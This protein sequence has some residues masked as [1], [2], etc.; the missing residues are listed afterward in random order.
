MLALGPRQ[1]VAQVTLLVTL[2]ALACA[3]LACS[4]GEPEPQPH[5]PA[6]PGPGDLAAARAAFVDQA[7]AQ[8]HA[9]WPAAART[10]AITE[11]RAAIERLQCN[12]CH[13]I[14]DIEPSSRPTHCVS[15]HQWLDGL[16]PSDP[17]YTK[18]AGRYGAH[19]MERYQRNIVHYLGVPD[20]TRVGARLRPDWIATYIQN[21]HDLR[22]MMEETM[23]RSQVSEADARTI[24]R[25]F[26]AVAETHDPY[27]EHTPAPP[28]QA[29]VRASAERIEEGRGVFMRRGCTLCHTVGNVDTGKTRAD[30]I[31][32]GA[33]AK[34]APNLRFA[35]ERM[36]PDLTAAW[37]LDPQ[38]FHPD[39]V[40]P[41]ANLTP[42]EAEAV[43]DF[44]FAVDP[45]LGPTPPVPELVLPPA[46]T[47]PVTWAEVKE[48]TLGR[49]CVHCHMNDHE[50]DNGPGN[51]GG[52]GWPGVGLRMRTYETL[53]SGQFE[54]G[55]PHTEGTRVSV[56][57]PREPGG[58]PL[59]LE[60][61]LRRRI[62]ERRDRVEAFADY[63]LPPD[64]GTEH[65]GMP[66]GL[67]SIP[68]AEL[69]LLRAWIEQGCPGPTEV[70]GMPGIDDGFLVPDGPIT[71]NHGC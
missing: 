37:I 29:P 56:L 71:V 21:P 45:R 53:V 61:M 8:N 12:R 50:R 31:R 46:V 11:G 64:H 5:P 33:V 67:P 24:A 48:S 9:S 62:E 18:L 36:R 7:L 55:A 63:E 16:E 60:A 13:T 65:L 38:R 10:T 54:R 47:R 4:G 44:L 2:S 35:R 57:E 25:Y 6:T 3:V 34:L 41:Q 22:P 42:A 19:V 20:L 52:Y 32:M 43:R 39:T 26:A 15:C 59:L 66:M 30:L 28:A 69:A 1:R 58:L 40:M 70:T 23:V 51:Q 27:G 49:I 17:T 14:D 68:D